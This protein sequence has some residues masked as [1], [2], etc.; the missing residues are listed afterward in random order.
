MMEDSTVAEAGRNDVWAGCMKQ[1]HL[2][3]HNSEIRVWK[4]VWKNF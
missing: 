2:D 4:D 1:V 3:G